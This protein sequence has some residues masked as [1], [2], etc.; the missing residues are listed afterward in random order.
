MRSSAFLAAAAATALSGCG[1]Y[2]PELAEPFASRSEAKSLVADIVEHLKCEVQYAVQSEVYQ[3]LEINEIKQ[4]PQFKFMNQGR[5]SPW[6]DTYGAQIT[7]MLTIDES[8]TLAASASFIDVLP[9]AQKQAL[10]AGGN[11]NAKSTRKETLSFF[12]P[13]KDLTTAK[14]MSAAIESGRVGKGYPCNETGGGAVRGDLKTKE[15]LDEVLLQSNADAKF[16]DAL[17]SAAKKKDVIQHEI[18]FYLTYGGNVN[19]SWSLTRFSADATTTL[20]SAARDNTQ[21]VIITMGPTSD[22]KSLNMLAQNTLLASQIRSALG[23]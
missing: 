1:T 11:L 7:L 6:L 10:G 15:W 14:A 4:R 21:D 16:G 23:F 22:G 9:Q 13:F 19:P 20:F 3:D 2:V 8:S 12:V 5:A 17:A 18:S